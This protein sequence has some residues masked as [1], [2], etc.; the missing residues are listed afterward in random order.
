[1]K[2]L[3]LTLAIPQDL[4]ERA[5]IAQVDIRQTVIE[6]LERKVQDYHPTVHNKMPTRAEIDAAVEEAQLQLESGEVQPR[7]WGYLKGQIWIADDFDDELPD[8]FWLSDDL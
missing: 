1:M 7:T 4:L 5:N 8:E 3:S 6:A 2:E